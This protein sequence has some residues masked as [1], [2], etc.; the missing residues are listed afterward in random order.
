M[1]WDVQYYYI[2]IPVIGKVCLKISCSMLSIRHIN[3]F[4]TLFSITSEVHIV[5]SAVGATPPGTDRGKRLRSPS[6]YMLPS[7]MTSR[8]FWTRANYLCRR[9]TDYWYPLSMYMVESR[10]CQLLCDIGNLW[11]CAALSQPARA[12]NT[13]TQCG[14]RQ[15]NI[16]EIAFASGTVT[17]G[18]SV[19]R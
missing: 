16:S 8:S 11:N 13:W 3:L 12:W 19:N 18:L 7:L 4:A 6:M 9:S 1:D 14:V 15:C 10:L 17:P 2:T 5:M